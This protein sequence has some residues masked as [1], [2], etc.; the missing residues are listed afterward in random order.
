[1]L[2]LHLWRVYRFLESA[3][4]LVHVH[5][6]TYSHTSAACRQLQTLWSW[7]NFAPGQKAP[8]Q[9]QIY[10][11]TCQF[12]PG[13]RKS[14][15]ATKHNKVQRNERNWALVFVHLW[16]SVYARRHIN[17]SWRDMQTKNSLNRKMERSTSSWTARF[18]YQKHIHSF[19]L[20]WHTGGHRAPNISVVGLTPKH[21]S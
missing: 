17:I 14:T 2:C 20:H 6:S 11:S 16:V 4:C 1:M 18:Y 15:T 12:S 8:A 7:H 21:V 13:S 10:S 9:H 5:I 3:V 19:I